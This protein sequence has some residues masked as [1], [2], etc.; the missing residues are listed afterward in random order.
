MIPDLLQTINNS[1]LSKIDLVAI[2]GAG[3]WLP[4]IIIVFYKYLVKPDIKIKNYKPFLLINNGAFGPFIN[5]PLSIITSR[6]IATINKIV[7]VLTNIENGAEKEYEWYATTPAAIRKFVSK[8]G[9]VDQLEVAPAGILVLE[10][11]R[12]LMAEFSFHCIRDLDELESI[13]LEIKNR[14]FIDKEKDDKFVPTN[15]YLRQLDETVELK[16]LFKKCVNWDPGLYG[17]EIEIYIY[18]KRK[19][20]VFNFEGELESFKAE[21]LLNDYKVYNEWVESENFLAQK[22]PPLFGF[23][24]MSL[25]NVSDSED[26]TDL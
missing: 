7:V 13:F 20:Y 23:A 21:I 16:K 26:T 17:I 8:E 10:T 15:T 6:R 25:K 24:S 22:E 19:P 2:V 12:P 11:N 14:S 4:W 1:I 5:I 3:A 9:N 18:E